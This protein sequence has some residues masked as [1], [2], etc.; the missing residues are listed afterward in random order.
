ME[1]ARVPDRKADAS[2][3]GQEK[4]ECCD[5]PRQEP[6]PLPLRGPDDEADAAHQVQDQLEHPLTVDYYCHFALGLSRPRNE[7]VTNILAL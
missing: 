4:E 6:P 2:K 5:D 1:R 3:V 7:F